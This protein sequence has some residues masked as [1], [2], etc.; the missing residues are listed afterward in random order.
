MVSAAIATV[1]AQQNAEAAHQHGR[2]VAD[3][4]R[5]TAPKLAALMDETEYDVLAFMDFQANRLRIHPISATT[6]AETLFAISTEA[7][8]PGFNET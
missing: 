4:M 8:G 3:P 1:L 5:T 6:D 7:A 2:S